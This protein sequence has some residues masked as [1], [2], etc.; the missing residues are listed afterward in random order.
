MKVLRAVIKGKM[1][2]FRKVYSNSTSLSYYFPPR[3][4]VLGIIAAALGKE[5]DSYYSEFN[6][7]NVGVATLTPL[8]KLVTAEDILDTD[9]LNTTKFRGF[10]NRV[11]TTKEIVIASRGDFLSYEIF[12]NPL[13]QELEK[14]MREPVYPLSLGPAN[15]LAWVDEVEEVDCDEL[16]SGSAEVVGAVPAEVKVKFSSK[17]QISL[18][19]TVPR[20]FSSGRVP[21]RARN[22]YFSVN[23]SP[24]EIEY[25]SPLNGVMC[26]GRGVVFL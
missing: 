20:D 15:M 16:P 3:T 18:E 21:G 13:N 14:S 5:R 7:Y 10:S 11:P 17:V 8:R 22:Y 26:N 6:V 2:H 12:I 4:T 19:D 1:A 23:G 25:N 9:E 24:Y